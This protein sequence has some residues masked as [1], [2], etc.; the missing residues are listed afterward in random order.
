M[1]LLV[2]LKGYTDVLY[3]LKAHYFL[4]AVFLPEE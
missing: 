1:A 3:L 2:T 4:R